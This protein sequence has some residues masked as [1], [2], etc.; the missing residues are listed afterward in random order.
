[1]IYLSLDTNRIKALFF[2]K[3]LLGQYDI[4]FFEKEF[5]L[6][7]VEKGK[8]IST[9]VLAS[10]IKE[11][12][13]NLLDGQTKDREVVLILP[14]ETFGFLRSE[15]P[16]DIAATALNSFLRDKVRSALTIDLSEYH[17]DCF[18][19]VNGNQKQVNL[20]ALANNVLSLYH[21]AFKLL[22]LKIVNIIPDTL[23]YFKLFDKTLRKDK[24][25][26]ILYM[27]YEKKR[28]YGY[29]FDSYGV[30]GE[31]RWQTDLTD[32]K[33]AE[34]YLEKK[35][36]E[37]EEKGQKINRL[38]LSGEESETVRQDTFTK[39][40]GIWTNP[41]KRIIT[42]FYQEYL[43]LLITPNKSFS[44]LSYDV[45]FGAFIFT[46][47]NKNFS[48]LKKTL[49]PPKA[50]RT[51]NFGRIFRREYLLFIISFIASFI[52]F[53]VLSKMNIRLKLPDISHIGAAPTATPT[54]T[55]MPP[56]PTPT[57][58]FKKEDL[59]IKVL[60]GGGVAGKA[61]EVT[62][63]LKKAGYSGTIN[64]GNADNFDYIKTVIQVKKSKAEAFNMLKNDFKDYTTTIKEETL[65]EKD[66]ADAILIVGQDFK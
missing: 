65:D 32:D 8:V 51:V 44:I 19:T 11:V 62:A 57:P 34:T 50:K 56:S 53:T 46:T 48:L 12:L 23:S 47:E 26:N 63:T 29:L 1:M 52:L 4:N 31:N 58:S 64:G 66:P 25:E 21:E 61:S 9:D 39:K 5:Q 40:V 20:Y 30:T 42:N 60:N 38:I 54:P 59:N 28:L 45:C 7:L 16:S 33:N 2:K 24:K 10:A 3:S 36:K 18:L 55:T 15:I 41:I 17:Y 37:Y 6:N 35:A 49:S 13:T 27:I 43:K 14:Q 22:D